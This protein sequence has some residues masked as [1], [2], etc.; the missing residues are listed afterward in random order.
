MIYS[1]YNKRDAT[2]YEQY[3]NMNTGLDAVLDISKTVYT[4]T[5][6]YN[7]RILLD[8]DLSELTS[9]LDTATLQSASYYLKLT[10]VEASEIPLEYTIYAYPVSQSWG[11]GTGRLGLNPTGSDGVSWKY[12]F[13]TDDTT[14]PWT[15]SS[16]NV[17]TTGY[18]VTT[19]GGGT[20]YTS[21]SYEATQSFS[22]ETTDLNLD[23]TNT[24]KAWI[25]GTLPNNGFIIKRSQSDEA[26][27]VNLGSIKFFS[28]D[29]HTIY[30]PKLE[31]RWTDATNVGTNPTAS[32]EDEVVL[33]ITNL[34]PE[35]Q[36]K[37]KARF[38]VMFRPKYPTI[39]FAT[40]SNYLDVYQLPP[41]SSYSI[42]DA[43]SGETVV[44]FDYDY[45]KI[46]SDSRGSYFRLWLDGLQPERYYRV[47]IK[48]K[49]SINEEYV[50]DRNWIFKV[51]R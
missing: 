38:N 15:T 41:S 28:K 10:T 39:T 40:A 5:A 16:F 4:S 1:I 8:F 14:K 48:T 35:Y 22:Y 6:L 11:M 31:V 42:L 13:G 12:R 2:I 23:V 37:S 47:A 29:T 45:T 3:P 19:P 46:S 20:W 17:N 36:Q 26:S 34:Q 25:S 7:N 32:F 27:T 50:F 30:Q 51:I 44:P 43:A 18:G 24:V 33:N 21:G 9:L 49:P